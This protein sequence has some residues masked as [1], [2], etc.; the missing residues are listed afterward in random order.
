M[1]DVIIAASLSLVVAVVC[2]VVAPCMATV[3][4]V[5][6]ST[7]W[8][9]GVDYTTWGSDKSFNV[10]D[11]LVFN[12]GG[13]HTVDEVSASDYSTCTVG[14]SITTDS[15]GA[16]SIALKTAGTH[17]FICA[18]TGHCGNGM[19]LAL[20]VKASSS[21]SSSSPPASTG[22]TTGG[23]TSSNSNTPP[24]T[25]IYKPASQSAASVIIVSPFLLT[26]YCLSLFLIIFSF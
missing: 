1:G 25:A 5:G 23:G 4:T 19:K 22:T 12:Y 15:S 6:D 17:Y 3:Y 18:A 21:S 7:G 24:A 13:G 10:G 9:M 11:T 16:T 26:T 2:M 20:N 8:A 14:N